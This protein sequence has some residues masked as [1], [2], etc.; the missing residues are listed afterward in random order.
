VV[1]DEPAPDDDDDGE[2]DDD[3]DEEVHTVGTG[4]VGAAGNHKLPVIPEA[5]YTDRQEF[6]RGGLGRVLRATDPSMGRS[7]AIKELLP[8]KEFAESRFIREALV[9]RSCR[10]TRRGAGR[11]AS[12]ST[13]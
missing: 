4:A 1:P 6:A 10:C 12:R 13:R 7:V 11:R 9:R 3:D 2:Y 5:T 8:G